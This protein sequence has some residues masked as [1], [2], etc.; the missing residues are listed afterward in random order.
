MTLTMHSPVLI[1]TPIITVINCE[2]RFPLDR[3]MI[4]KLKVERA[5]LQFFEVNVWLNGGRVVRNEG[6]GKDSSIFPFLEKLNLPFGEIVVFQIGT[7]ETEPFG[8]AVL[9][10]IEFSKFVVLWGCHYCSIAA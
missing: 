2:G 8:K 3:L 7:T 6:T 5:T 10:C 4:V 9:E 1:L